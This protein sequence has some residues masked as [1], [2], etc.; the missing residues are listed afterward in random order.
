ME[1]DSNNYTGKDLSGGID[2]LYPSQEVFDR[3]FV[4]E[5]NV[6][7][8][9][10]FLYGATSGKAFFWGYSG[11]RFC[12]RNSGALAVVSSLHT[13][14]ILLLVFFFCNRYSTFGG[15]TCL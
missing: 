13:L 4:P 9:N 2:A 15:G 14:V 7:V 10:I 1:G 6:I 5:D 11:E 8:R 12:V 3:G